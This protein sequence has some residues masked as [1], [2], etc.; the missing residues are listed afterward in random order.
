[1]QPSGVENVRARTD[2][3]LKAS[4]QYRTPGDLRE[5]AS[6]HF[7]TRRLHRDTHACLNRGVLDICPSFCS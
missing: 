4:R 3:D 1:M 7:R 6:G 5:A 2:R